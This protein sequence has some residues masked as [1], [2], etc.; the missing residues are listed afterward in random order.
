MLGVVNLDLFDD[1]NHRPD[2][3]VLGHHI[4]DQL[5]VMAECEKEKDALDKN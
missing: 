1:F 5:D 2:A 4:L 3:L